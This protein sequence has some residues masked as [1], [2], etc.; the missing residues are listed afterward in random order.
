MSFSEEDFIRWAT[1]PASDPNDA[2]QRLDALPVGPGDDAACLP[3]GTIVC[4][5][6]VVEGVH[7]APG[8]DADAIARKALGA[9][10]SDICAMGAVA[11]TVLVAAQLSPGCDGPAL[12]RGLNRWARE[13]GV[14]LAGG[15]TVST[16]AG[17]LA[18]SVTATGHLPDGTEPWRRSGAR[19][20]DRLLVTGPLGGAQ[21][22]R[23]LA[24][25]PRAD[26]VAELRSCG[27]AVHA[28][29]DLSDGLAMDLPRL[30]TA[31]GVGAQI[32]ASR[33][34]IHADVPQESDSILAALTDGE[35]FELLLALGP[36]TDVPSGAT[37]IGHVL[38][39]GLQLVA[40]DGTVLPW[41][42][43]GFAHAF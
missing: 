43:T 42:R 12:A 18:L 36:D 40:A 1:A 6:S 37:I 25:T 4:V 10:L 26:V 22:G 24:V 35:D 29:M 2:Q 39:E 41:P 14:V 28:A 27:A 33:L 5:D 23:H 32:E 13:F 17:A 9:C 21:A 20:G 31:S 38:A 34:P 8:T 15:D 19:P 11:E 16:H 7:F 3:D 30:L